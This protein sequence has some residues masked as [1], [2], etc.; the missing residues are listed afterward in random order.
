MTVLGRREFL[1]TGTGLLVVG[2]TWRPPT[3]AQT[4]AVGRL[5]RGPMDAG[6]LDA[7]LT[8]S[9]DGRVTFYTGRI[10]MGTGVQTAFAQ[11]L[12]DELEVPYEAVTIVMG[13]TSLTPDQG[14]STASSNI[15]RGLLPLRTAAAEARDTL[16][17]PGWW[18]GT[19]R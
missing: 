7:W 14:K 1:A 17:E 3:A 15:N 11:V 2:V 18:C 12:A 16:L 19:A 4:P 6:E 5:P 10:D 9:A 13:D 8:L